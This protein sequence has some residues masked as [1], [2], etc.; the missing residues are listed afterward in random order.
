M[1]DKSEIERWYKLSSDNVRLKQLLLEVI[2]VDPG[3]E[4]VCWVMVWF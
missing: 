1:Y 4:G 3:I 2:V